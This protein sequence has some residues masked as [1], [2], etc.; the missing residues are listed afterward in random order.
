MIMVLLWFGNHPDILVKNIS[1]AQIHP[2]ENSELF[3]TFVDLLSK[4]CAYFSSKMPQNWDVNF[5]QLSTH[6]NSL[7]L[8]N[9]CTMPI[10]I[11]LRK[12]PALIY[13]R[14]QLNQF[15]YQI[16]VRL[17][18]KAMCAY[19]GRFSIFMPTTSKKLEGHIASEVSVHSSVMLCDA[20]H[21]FRTLYARILKFHMQK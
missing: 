13:I 6:H 9:D 20:E 2:P 3:N 14:N 4:L 8:Y 17:I 1:H 12:H 21:N 15:Y 16:S 7:S 11:F 5:I 10:N 18:I 19:K